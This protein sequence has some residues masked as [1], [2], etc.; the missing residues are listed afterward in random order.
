MIAS[1]MLYT[2]ENGRLRRTERY[3][4]SGS[5]SP[6]PL[7]YALFYPEKIGSLNTPNMMAKIFIVRGD[8][9]KIKEFYSS[10]YGNNP[11]FFREAVESYIKDELSNPQQTLSTE[12]KKQIKK[13]KV[14][15]SKK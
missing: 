15:R 10:K 11:K 1:A 4:S 6:L 13:S 9:R 2:L 7:N 8:D 14:K 5:D 12:R 3:G